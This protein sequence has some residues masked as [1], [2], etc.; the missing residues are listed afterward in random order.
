[1]T[2]IS[3]SEHAKKLVAQYSTVKVRILGYGGFVA[4]LTP[5]K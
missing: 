5:V 4:S 2:L 3:D 1:M